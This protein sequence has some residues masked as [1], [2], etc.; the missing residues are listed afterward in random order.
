MTFLSIRSFP[1]GSDCLDVSPQR[2]TVELTLRY[3]ASRLEPSGLGWI[4]SDVVR[5]TL[6][7]TSPHLIRQ[8][9]SLVVDTL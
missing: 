7:F 3:N 1:H 5:R 8:G 2:S 9:L 4:Q 6:D